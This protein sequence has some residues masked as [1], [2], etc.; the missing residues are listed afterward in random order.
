MHEAAFGF[1]RCRLC[2]SCDQWN[3]GETTPHS[4]PLHHKHETTTFQNTKGRGLTLQEYTTVFVCVCLVVCSVL[5]PSS[6]S[7][8]VA[9]RLEARAA[10]AS[11]SPATSK[12][13]NATLSSSNHAEA[14]SFLNAFE[15]AKRSF[16]NRMSELAVQ[17]EVATKSNN[18]SNTTTAPS[19]EDLLEPIKLR[20]NELNHTLLSLQRSTAESA[21]LLTSYDLRSTKIQLA[22]LEESLAHLSDMIVPKKRFAFKKKTAPS[23]AA[24][25]AAA[26]A[27]SSAAAATSS[28]APPASSVQEQLPPE[29][30]ITGFYRKENRILVKAGSVTEKDVMLQ[31][32]TNCVVFILDRPSALRCH[33]LNNC[34][35]YV[36]PCSGSILIY[37]SNHCTFHLAS[38]QLR[39]HD[40]HATTFHLHALSSP[41][42]EHT[43]TT[44]FTEYDFSYPNL[45]S[46]LV[47]SGFEGKMSRHATV[48]DFNWLRSQQ[49]PNWYVVMSQT[50]R[51]VNL[52]AE[53]VALL[54]DMTD[55][56][57][58]DQEKQEQLKQIAREL[59]IIQ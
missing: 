11:T 39:I 26:A 12:Q 51:P 27:A 54:T 34:H 52:Q 57:T 42:I 6:F 30:P 53:Q 45:A 2:P 40:T 21:H 35:V 28:A 29:D 15:E 14:A 3:R 5:L 24:A 7:M 10:A 25:T 32:L 37:G 33:N 4:I 44:G 18:N 55:H 49:S 50:R 1:S 43:N 48:E 46:D 16:E 9:A 38:R 22:T 17:T 19:G 41:I 20:L 31:H 8:S 47:T 59:G 36:G 56:Q 23:T 13:D 58:D